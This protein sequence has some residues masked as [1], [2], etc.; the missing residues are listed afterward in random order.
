MSSDTLFFDCIYE[1]LD[2]LCKKYNFQLKIKDN[3]FSIH[4][5]Q[6]DTIY[7]I[8]SQDDWKISLQHG[9]NVKEILFNRI[10]LEVEKYIFSNFYQGA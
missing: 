2:D 3:S 10:Y 6:L 8:L 7:I 5:D 1:E 9:K 4:V